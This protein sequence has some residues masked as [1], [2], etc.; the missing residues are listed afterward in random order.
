MNGILSE[1]IEIP[2]PTDRN[3]YQLTTKEMIKEG[4]NSLPG[5]L[6]EALGEFYS[7]EFMKEVFGEEPFKNF[8]YAKLEEYDAYRVIVSEWERNRYISRL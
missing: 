4:I 6:S 1:D 7:S 5:S 8:Y 2:E 3:V